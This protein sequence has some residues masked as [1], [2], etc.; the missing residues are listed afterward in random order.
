MTPRVSG[1]GTARVSNKRGTLSS[2]LLR[3]EPEGFLAGWRRLDDRNVRTFHCRCGR[4]SALLDGDFALASE[5]Q[6]GPN[7]A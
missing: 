5:F 1:V 6:L 7:V 3:R 4:R 2:G